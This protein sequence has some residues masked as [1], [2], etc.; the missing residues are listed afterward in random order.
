MNQLIPGLLLASLAAAG[1]AWAGLVSG[2]DAFQ[3]ATVN[4]AS[5]GTAGAA[6]SFD[7]SRADPGNVTFFQSGNA[8]DLGFLNFS[9]GSAV[10]LDG[11]RLFAG[12]DGAG[13][14]FRRSMNAFRFYADANDDGIWEELINLAVNVNYALMPGNVAAG[15][16]ELELSLL[17]GSAVTSSRWRYEVNQGVSFGTF[18]GVRIQEVDAISHVPEPAS[19]ALV[20]LALAAA[21]L[22]ARRRR[23]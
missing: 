8:G 6:A 13:N 9:T 3:G 12:N 2:T 14:G 15:A 18:D 17:F 23:G 10:T 22:G 4:A 11:I 7:G 5:G 19:F 20:P 16:Q 21:G 1:P